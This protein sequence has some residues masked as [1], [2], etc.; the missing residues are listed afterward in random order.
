MKFLKIILAI[1]I[2]LGSTIILSII[3]NP[4]IILY[5]APPQYVITPIILT[6][7]AFAILTLIILN[8]YQTLKNKDIFTYVPISAFPL[9]INLGFFVSVLFSNPSRHFDFIF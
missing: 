7:S 9:V 5:S 6:G 2:S 8:N 1:G 3:Y 4:G